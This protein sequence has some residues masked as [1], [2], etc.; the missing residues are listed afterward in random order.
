MRIGIGDAR[1]L[2]GE[3]NAGMAGEVEGGEPAIAPIDAWY[4]DGFSPARNPEL[5][6]ADLLKVAADLTA[7]GGTLAT[8]TAAGWVRRNLQAAG[9]EIEKAEG[10]AGKREMVKGRKP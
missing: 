8:Y 6:D 3:L 5:W 7:H 9:F 1:E 10:F 2:I 4:F